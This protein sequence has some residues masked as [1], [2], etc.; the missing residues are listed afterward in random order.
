MSVEPFKWDNAQWAI[1]NNKYGQLLTYNLPRYNRRYARGDYQAHI[2]KMIE[3]RKYDTFVDVGAYIGFFS[4]IA[5]HH[6]SN[7]IAYEAHPFY[8]GILL[9]NMR[10]Y[11]NVSCR[12][13]FVSME[14][15][16]PKMN[17]IKALVPYE[18]TFPYNI[19]VV[20]LDSEWGYGIPESTLIKLDVEGNE[21]K[22][23]E[24]SK[25]ILKKPFV[26]WI[27]DIHTQY[28]IKVEEILE[29]FPQRQITMFSQK[30]IKVEGL[31]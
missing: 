1:I 29:Y 22:V 4:Q 26:H 3:S 13:R 6:C 12:Y 5:T 23:L 27:I 20:S 14:G 2:T 31:L 10:F 7:I 9:L 30:V 21:L 28:G 8:Y 24:G 11:M 16:V 18:G 17:G 19:E 15:D 25:E